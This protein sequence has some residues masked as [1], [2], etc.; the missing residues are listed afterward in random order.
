MLT[1]I[2]D[3]LKKKGVDVYFA[4]QREGE[5]ITPYTVITEGTR[6]Q[7]QTFTTDV[8]YYT[9]SVIVP[10]GMYSK[11]SQYLDIV[12]EHL[13]ELYP[14]VKQTHSRTMVLW[15]DIANG[16]TVSEDFTTYKKWKRRI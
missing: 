12:V 9:V 13:K 14:A 3:T 16:W 4:G 1:K 5:C 2:Y 7:Y 6:S 11:A 15:D 10:K 8:C